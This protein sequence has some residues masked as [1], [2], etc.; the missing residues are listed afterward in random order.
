[1]TLEAGANSVIW[2]V[3]VKSCGVKYCRRKG[4]SDRTSMCQVDSLESVDK[5][6]KGDASLLNIKVIVMNVKVKNKPLPT[7]FGRYVRKLRV[8]H[9]ER[10]VD[11]G[12]KLSISGGYLSML[13]LG[14]KEPTDRLIQHL[15]QTYNLGEEGLSTLR[16]LA[17]ISS[18]SITIS[19]EGYSEEDRLLIVLFARRFNSFSKEQ[20]DALSEILKIK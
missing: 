2:K 7:P 10:L 15:V 17:L 6:R 20:K 16:D 5:P 1:M 13:E 9:S 14:N 3:G 18:N 4:L 8:D 12:N 19:L 11:M